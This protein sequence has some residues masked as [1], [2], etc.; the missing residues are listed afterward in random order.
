MNGVRGLVLMWPVK[1]QKSLLRAQNLNTLTESLISLHRR[2][3]MATVHSSLPN[4]K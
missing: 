3:K 4:Q 2:L 1:Q